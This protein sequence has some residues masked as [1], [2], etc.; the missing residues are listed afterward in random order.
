MTVRSAAD[1]ATTS[2]LRILVHV[3]L[4]TMLRHFESVLLAL[5][6]RGH[7]IRIASPDRRRDLAPPPPLAANERI[8][9]VSCP[10]R[11]GDDWAEAIHGLRSVRDYVRYTEGRFSTAPKLRARALRKM[12][13]AITLEERAHLVARCPRCDAR[14]VDDDIGRMLLAAGKA[15]QAGLAQLLA[16]M[17]ATIP[18]DPTIEAFL[19]TEQPDVV[20][21]TPLISIG[22]YQADY[23]KSAKAL[24]LPVVFP[25]FSWDNLSN[26]GLIH[27]VPDRVLVWNETQRIEAIKMHHVPKEQVVVTGAP[28]FDEFFAMTPQISRQDLCRSHAF[29][30]DRPILSY[31]CSSEFVAGH[32][33]DFVSRWIDEVRQ[34]PVLARCNILIRPHPR[35]QSQWKKFGRGRPHVAVSFPHSLNGDQSL[36]DTLHHSAAVVGLNTSAQLEAAIV[37][38]PV[39]TILA[40]EFAA[41]QQGT[42]HFRYLLKKR[43]GFVELAPDFTTHRRQ[44]AAAVGGDYDRDAI[45]AF[46][47]R[48]LRPA[49]LEQPATP[50]MVQAIEGIAR[51]RTRVTRA[52]ALAPL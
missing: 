42:L 33:I 39:L 50:I 22:S 30:P 31:L 3:T 11:R 18:S 16:L 37:G 47:Q 35:E 17:E 34:E 25:V 8:S 21:V 29:D 46:V 15:G 12:V 13:K 4:T 1:R 6:D 14:L 43:G 45:R 20:L 9:F 49:G 27:V 28:R 36:F 41:G 10:G 32:E 7:V 48:F 2:G 51:A 23:V 38:K 26:K 24:G 40:P 44:L 5:A 19:R 52:G